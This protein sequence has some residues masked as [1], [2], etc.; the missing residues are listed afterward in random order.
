MA[1][2]DMMDIN[3]KKGYLCYQK[4]DDKKILIPIGKFN[5]TEDSKKQIMS[6]IAPADF[7]GTSNVIKMKNEEEM[8]NSFWDK[9]KTTIELVVMG[10]FIFLSIIFIMQYANHTVTEAGKILLQAKQACPTATVLPSSAP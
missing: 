2:T 3:G 7:R 8:F 5:M 6:Q 9:Y 1:D 4:P 10:M